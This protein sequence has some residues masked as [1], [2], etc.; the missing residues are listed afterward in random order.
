MTFQKLESVRMFEREIRVLM[1]NIRQSAEHRAR[2]IHPELQAS[3][4]QVLLFVAE[5]QPTRA[6]AIADCL[7]MDKGAISRHVTTLQ[8]LG[9]I[10]RDCDPLDRRAQVL[11]LTSVGKEQIG[12]ATERRRAELGHRLQGWSEGE[13]GH[14]TEQLAR[15]NA[16]MAR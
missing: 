12:A 7:N 6:W 4:Y 11:S 14:F 8:E 16:D 1:R 3:T 10:E 5:N 13:L 2:L 9:F 15:F